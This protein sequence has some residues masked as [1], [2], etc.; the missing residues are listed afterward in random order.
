MDLLLKFAERVNWENLTFSAL[1]LLFTLILLWIAVTA[2]KILLRRMEVRL[3]AISEKRGEIPSEA[4]K[5]ADAGR[6]SSARS[7]DQQSPLRRISRHCD[8]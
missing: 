5:R 6:N 8:R 2:V 4:R 7:S 3:V 1:R